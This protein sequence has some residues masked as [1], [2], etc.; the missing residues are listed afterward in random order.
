M[1]NVP[2]VL[3]N[4]DLKESQFKK[5]QTLLPEYEILTEPRVDKLNDTEVVVHWSKEIAKLW[6]EEK[7]PN[8]KWVQ[9]ISAGVNYLPLEG[10]QEKGIVL[11]NASGIHKYTITEYVIG[12]LLNYLRDFDQLKEN[13]E[14]KYWTNDVRVEQ[15][16]GKT[17]LIYGIGSIGRQLA[18]VCQ[19]F[20]MHVIGVNTSG[21]AVDEADETVSQEN[22]DGQM[23]D[24]DIIVNILP[25]TPETIDFFDHQRFQNMK[26]GTIFVNVGRGSSVDTTALLEALDNDILAF[27][28]LDVFETEPLETG[29]PLWKHEKVFISPHNSGKVEH[30]R[31]ALF[32]VIEPNMRAYANDGKP[33]LNVV[34]YDKSY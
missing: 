17:I 19:S 11:T 15:L 25:E 7:L 22:S 33:S 4:T 23:Q 1:F 27:A 28:A 5:I 8:L 21:N 18:R 9:A 32:T 6:Q 2:N 30:F 26:R 13:Q 10:F 14:K 24:A 20:G 12:A 31:D 34:D 16:N 29:S 3:I